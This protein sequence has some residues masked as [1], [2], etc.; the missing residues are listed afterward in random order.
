MNNINSIKT[1]NIDVEI[2]NIDSVIFE[3]IE[4]SEEYDR[5]FMSQNILTRLRNLIEHT[6]LK[7]LSN[8]KG[9]ELE[10][11]Y[12]NI[13]EA[14]KY[15]KNIAQY[16]F[17]SNFHRFVQNSV[18]HIT[19]TNENAERLMLK[20]YEYL[21]KIKKFYKTNYCLDILN[22]IDKFP[23]NTDMTYYQYYGEIAQK[24]DSISIIRNEKFID[25]RYYI[26]K[27]KPFF[28]NDKIYYEVTLSPAKGVSNKL[29]RITM[30]TKCEINTNYAIK[31]ST[32]KVRAKI[33]GTYTEIQ[34]INNWQT[35][36]RP[37]EIKNMY[38][39][40]GKS[41]EYSAGYKEYREIMK[42]LTNTGYNLFDLANMDREYYER[43]KS[44]FNNIVNTNYIFGLIDEARNIIKNN[45]CGS[46]ILRYLL[47]NL[48]NIIIKKQY[49]DEQNEML[50]NLYLKWESIP[51]EKMPFI[52]SLSGHNPKSYDLFE[53]I[54]VQNRKD[55]L[56][57]KYVQTNAEQNGCLYTLKSELTAFGNVE[58]LIKKYNS[59]LYYKHENRKIVIDGDNVYIK[60][61]E[62]NTIN[63]IKKLRELSI[64]GIKGYRNSVKFWMNEEKQMIDD[65]N[66]KD[67]L[68][69]LFDN[70][71]VALIYGAAGTGKT[72]MVRYISS[73]YNDDKKIYLANTHPAIENLRRKV[74]AQNSEFYTIKRILTNNR[75]NKECKV[76]IIDECSTVSNEDMIKILNEIQFD[77]LILVGDIYQIESIIF[78]NW[79]SIAKTLIDDKAIYELLKPFRT[80][81]ENLK[82]LWDK[83]RNLD[84][85][86]T[87]WMVKNRYSETLNEEIL[88]SSDDDEI[89]LCLNYDGLYGIN[90][91]N[92]F[93]QNRNKNQAIDWGIGTYKVGDPILFNESNRF[94]PIIYNNMK[95]KIVQIQLEE[96]RIWFD[97]EINTVIDELDAEDVGLELI[98]NTKD[99]SIVRFFVNEFKDLDEDDDLDSEAVVPFSVAYAVSIHKAQGLEYNSVK[100]IITQ[101]IEE[102]ISHNIFYTAITR[103]MQKLKIYWTP[104][105]QKRIISTMKPKFNKKDANIIKNKVFGEM[106]V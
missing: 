16:K 104:E 100:V 35:A 66:K 60:E 83:V 58:E 59:K 17:L 7:I 97:I 24:I 34:I 29:D 106:Y 39:I 48:N 69:R 28:I 43:I 53:C 63:I 68:E 96:H 11:N 62:E 14:V 1:D 74:Y 81:N 71:R 12:D 86:I 76:L 70:S 47:Y 56:L 4:R 44:Y 50:S 87:E 90:N 101:E 26:Q 13:E 77:L 36:I 85:D 15:I 31:V 98:E 3:N 57:A 30:F 20:Y 33:F 27:I 95:G 55:E 19:P 52:T 22:N 18:G 23:L 73:Y 37:C 93:M 8:V 10:V 103:A 21:I 2:K 54:D 78:G 65:E 5:G 79:F 88:K 40:F 91:I 102:I 94:T 9:I 45:F 61:Y 72:T 75:I 80:K 46:N 38:K 64:E 92:R 67:I 82:K 25:G 89:I 51:F 32:V 84:D 41:I 42:F 99:K 49:K 105:C 6:A